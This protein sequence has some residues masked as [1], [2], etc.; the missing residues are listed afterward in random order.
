MAVYSQELEE[1]TKRE[2]E[3]HDRNIEALNKRKEEL[4]EENKRKLQVPLQIFTDTV[5]LHSIC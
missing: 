3:K 4:L 2:K 5:F 1:E